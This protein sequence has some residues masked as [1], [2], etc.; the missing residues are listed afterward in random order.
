M[1]KKTFRGIRPDDLYGRMGL[2]NPERGFR[3]EMYFSHIPGEVAGLCSCHSKQ[4]KLDG[5]PLKP[6]FQ[7]IDVPG[8][9]HLIRGNRLDGVEFAHH[10]WMDE[11][12][13]LS[14]DGITIM[15]SYCFLMKYD[16]G[17]PLPQEKLDDI[18]GFFLKLRQR[19]VKALLRFAYELSPTL[20]GPSGETVLKHL[21]QL[22]PLIRKYIDVIYVLQCGFV[23]KFGEWHNS[24][25]KLQYDL[26][27]RK[28]LMATV[29]EVLPPTR[30]TMMRYPNLKMELFGYEP[31]KDQEAFTSLPQA[32]IG[33][34]NDGFMAGVSNGGTFGR[35]PSAC[36]AE[37]E[38]AYLEQ[39]GRFLPM[40]GELFWRDLSGMALPD[41]ALTNLS[42]WHYDTL[43]MVHGNS[44]F[45]GDNYS[46][47]VWKSVPVDPMG[48]LN[49]NMKFSHDY[50]VDENG[51]HVWRSYYEYIRDH[52]GYRIELLEAEISDEIVPGGTINASIKLVNR[53]F[54]APVNPRP[55]KL[56][57]SNGTDTFKFRFK[58]D[59]RRW[60]GHSTE[61]LLTLSEPVPENMA[62]GTYQVGFALPD[63][64][65]TLREVHEYAIKTANP[66]EFRNGVNYLGMECLCK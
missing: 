37:A 41:E 4:T 21:S 5:R 17:R 36:S 32:R 27:F 47:D 18:E 60:E 39:E 25:Y 42:K 58:A 52:L 38:Q 35:N 49:K 46:I 16:D 56:I 63:G 3:T 2:R 51:K 10:Q 65:E 26:G 45:E 19:K 57:L 30:M 15:Q 44:L 11:L 34:F 55:V 40:D 14:Y 50:F 22:T 43:G 62:P 31:L 7:N 53:G 6:V 9:P 12:D 64:T 23:G 66:L 61:Q 28:E 48:L 54:S 59:V 24:Y 20:S 1:S 13:Y 33:H 29:L 8:V